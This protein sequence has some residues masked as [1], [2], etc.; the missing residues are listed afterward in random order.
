[1]ENKIPSRCH[2]LKSKPYLL[3]YDIYMVKKSKEI[4]L[5]MI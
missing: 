4:H 5:Q 1:M 3:V 2:K